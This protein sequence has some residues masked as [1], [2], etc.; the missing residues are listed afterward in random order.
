MDY[1]KIYKDQYDRSL[2]T[3]LND[4]IEKLKLAKSNKANFN[5]EFNAIKKELS[6]KPKEIHSQFKNDDLLE[7]SELFSKRYSLIDEAEPEDEKISIVLNNQVLKE[8]KKRSNSDYDYDEFIIK[9]A[10]L[11]ATNKI[12]SHFS[13]DRNYFELI[14]FTGKY[15]YLNDNYFDK[16]RSQISK[17]IAK[18]NDIKYPKEIEKINP[19]PSQSNFQDDI[20]LEKDKFLILHTLISLIK[21]KK[22]STI[23]IARVLVLTNIKKSK[24]LSEKYRNVEGYK[25]LSNGIDAVDS[26]KNKKEWILSVLSKLEPYK[27]KEIKAKLRLLLKNLNEK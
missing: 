13:M 9:L 2:E 26:Y 6:E 27:L 23:E 20:L 4:T 12:N 17:E 19:K 25:I 21:S 10:K 15:H 1:Y 3:I 18:M 14:Y 11:D 5:T 8:Y 16:E 22:M 7:C 24:L